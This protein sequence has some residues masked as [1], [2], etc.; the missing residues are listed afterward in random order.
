MIRPKSLDERALARIVGSQRQCR[1]K[2]TRTVKTAPLMKRN[3]E[4]SECELDD[5]KRTPGPEVESSVTTK[6]DPAKAF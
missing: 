5:F 4:I 3:M 6:G 2:A 1:Q